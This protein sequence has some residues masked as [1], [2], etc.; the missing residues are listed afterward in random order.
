[1]PAI[2]S[3]FNFMD[4]H[5]TVTLQQ[6][7]DTNEV[8]FK[9]FPQRSEVLFEVCNMK[10]RR[11]RVAPISRQ[12]PH[13]SRRVWRHVT[14]AL[15]A[16]DCDAATAAKRAVE[17]AQRDAAKLRDHGAEKWLTQVL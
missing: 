7:F 8:T 11:K 9:K 17:Q 1:M 6:I 5:L 15:H 3:T 2:N 13:E 4:K 10:P 16:A 12:L 14:C